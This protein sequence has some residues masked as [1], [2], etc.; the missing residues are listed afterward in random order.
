MDLC[1]YKQ[2]NIDLAHRKAGLRDDKGLSKKCDCNKRVQIN[3]K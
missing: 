1:D 3:I 2:E